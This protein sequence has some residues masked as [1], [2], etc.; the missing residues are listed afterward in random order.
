MGIHRHQL[1]TDQCQDRSVHLGRSGSGGAVLRADEDEAVVRGDH[2]RAKRYLVMDHYRLEAIKCL[3]GQAAWLV[4]TSWGQR[5]IR[6][7]AEAL[8]ERG[9]LTG[10]DVRAI[11]DDQRDTR[12]RRTGW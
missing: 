7:V 1:S 2:E 11:C 5:G 12:A 3:R 10:E 8:L 6:R 9:T 4:R